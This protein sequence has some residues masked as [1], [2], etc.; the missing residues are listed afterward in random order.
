VTLTEADRKALQDCLDRVLAEEPERRSQ[1]ENML[2]G[3]G[4]GR[5]WR[6][7]AIFCAVHLQRQALRVRPW[8]PVPADA[9]DDGSGWHG[10]SEE[11]LAARLRLMRDMRE[12]GISFFVADP[13]AEL[14][15]VPA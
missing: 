1:I 7:T 5:G 15:K 13:V 3:E 10:E 11:I 12:R 8:H 4:F 9:P 14:A 2:K 6:S